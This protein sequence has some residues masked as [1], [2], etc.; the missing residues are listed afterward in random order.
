MLLWAGHADSTNAFACSCG[1]SW[2]TGKIPTSR[3]KKLYIVLLHRRTVPALKRG[4][5]QAVHAAGGVRG[6]VQLRNLLVRGQLVQQRA[7]AR[8]QR[9]ARIAPVRVAGRRRV[10]QPPRQRVEACIA[11][12]C[13]HWVMSMPSR[14]QAGSHCSACRRHASETPAQIQHLRVLCAQHAEHLLRCSPLHHRWAQGQLLS[15]CAPSVASSAIAQ[16]SS[17]KTGQQPKPQDS[18]YSGSAGW[19]GVEDAL[20]VTHPR[21]HYHA[22]VCRSA[23]TAEAVVACACGC[24]CG[25]LATLR[26]V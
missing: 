16:Q 20:Q 21:V 17:A 26:H 6:R 2:Q 13:V 7:H 23:V 14:Q 9:R 12:A 24:A 5:A 11:S 8:R 10:R 15:S 4:D 25:V 3:A 1:Q 18:V 19:K 22:S